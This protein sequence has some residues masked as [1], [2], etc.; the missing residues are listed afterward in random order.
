M[1]LQISSGDIS[2][3]AFSPPIAAVQHVFANV[4]GIEEAALA[5]HKAILARVE[6]I[7]LKPRQLLRVAGSL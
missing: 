1:V 4:L 7:V 3:K 2:T 5:Q 6:R